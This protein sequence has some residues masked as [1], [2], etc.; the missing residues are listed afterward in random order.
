MKKMGFREKKVL[1]IL[2]ELKPDLIVFTG[3]SITWAGDARPAL[4]FLSKLKAPLGVYG[5]MGDYDYSVSRQSCVYCHKPGTGERTGAHRVHMLKNTEETV[6]LEKG[7]L[8]I[9]GLD[10]WDIN[11]D[12]AELFTD[13]E[14][15]RAPVIVLS[16]SPLRFDDI[17]GRSRVFMMAGD[18]HG[19]QIPMPDWVWKV[20]GYEKNVKY[21]KGFFR[22]NRK[23]MVVSRGIGTSHIP[24]RLFCP[25]EIVVYHF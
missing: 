19:G 1:G 18:T 15:G 9:A 5:V 17:D 16:H 24:L 22:E 13:I 11:T 10:E 6:T 23:F 21:N 8:T 25:P 4:G 20:L 2:E 7:I 3:D 12:T 14:S